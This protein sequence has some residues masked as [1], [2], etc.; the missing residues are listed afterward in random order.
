MKNIFWDFISM[1]YPEYCHGCG[2]DL[3]KGESLICT[4]CRLSLPVTNAHLE[5]N[6]K[7]RQRFL[8]KIPIEYAI[9]YLKFTQGGKVQRLLHALKY[10]NQPEVGELLGYWYG[11]ELK[12]KELEKEFDLIIPVPLHPAKLRI[13]GYNQS[14]AIAKGMSASMNTEWSA[15]I[16]I[17][18]IFTDT[19]TRKKRFARFENVSSV[20]ELLT[21][22]KI[23]N[24][25][26]LIID[27]V[28]TTGSTFESCARILLDNGAAKISVAALAAA[29]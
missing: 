17:R 24:K 12:S 26:I 14:D 7:L 8:G 20:F 2:N 4:P 10:N 21:A 5:Y 1:I 18:K 15:D 25:H 6:N 16:M 11:A 28:M 19:Q 27:D 23:I 9:A 3:E 13:R 29:F 22:Q